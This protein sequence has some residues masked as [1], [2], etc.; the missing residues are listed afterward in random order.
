MCNVCMYDCACVMHLICVACACVVCACVM[1]GVC[2]AHAAG[3]G[4]RGA[5]EDQERAA[6]LSDGGSLAPQASGHIGGAAA[7][8]A[9]A[10]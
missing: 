9:A 5:M 4:A 10:L 3:E 7:S 2:V 6:G 1:Y 8:P